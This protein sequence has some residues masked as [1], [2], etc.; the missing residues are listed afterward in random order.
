MSAHQRM[1]NEEYLAKGGANC[2]ACQSHAI[3]STGIEIKP[4]AADVHNECRE[5][6]ATWQDAY[7]LERYRD[8]ETPNGRDETEHHKIQD[9]G[10]GGEYGC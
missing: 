10:E 6:G 4:A 8:L 5:C 7:K 2:P 1:S 3:H 9:L